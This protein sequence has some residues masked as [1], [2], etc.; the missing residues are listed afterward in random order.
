MRKAALTAQFSP[1]SLIQPKASSCAAIAKDY[2]GAFGQ[3]EQ[4]CGLIVSALLADPSIDR[5]KGKLIWLKSCRKDCPKTGGTA[6]TSTAQLHAASASKSNLRGIGDASFG[7][8]GDTALSRL[9][10]T[11]ALLDVGGIRYPKRPASRNRSGIRTLTPDDNA[12]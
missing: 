5:S 12:C 2:E 7:L 3:P 4:A 10:A 9:G 6:S 11:G 1:E 8:E